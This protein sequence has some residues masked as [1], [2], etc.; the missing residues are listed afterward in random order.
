MA[1]SAA[2][3]LESLLRLCAEVAPAPWYPSQYA[4]TTGIDRD[5]LDEPLTQLRLAG[6]LRLT[7]WERG[8]GQGYAV[9]DDG[10]TVLANPRMV[11]RLRAGPVPVAVPAESPLARTQTTADR[12]EAVRTALLGSGGSPAI[13]LL[14]AAQ[15]VVFL[16][17]MY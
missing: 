17:G 3:T 4:Q 1:A 7:D 8:K 16:V 11:A 14:V 6:L 9:T 5:R 10:R 2:L 13:L 12:G 15:V